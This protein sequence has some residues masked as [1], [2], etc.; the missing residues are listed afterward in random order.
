MKHLLQ[1]VVCLIASL[2]LTTSL[3]AQDESKSYLTLP[4]AGLQEGVGYT[5]QTNGRSFWYSNANRLVTSH[6]AG[7]TNEQFDPTD[8]AAVF[9]F[10]SFDDNNYI[11]SVKQ[12][13]FLS[14]DVSLTAKG[15]IVYIFNSGSTDDYHTF[16][17]FTQDKRDLNINDNGNSFVFNGWSVPDAGDQFKVTATSIT[18]NAD[19]VRTQLIQALTADQ[20]AV[21]LA[22]IHDAQ[23]LG[24]DVS[25]A[26]A[27]YDNPNATPSAVSAAI[28]A[29]A[30]AM[31][32]MAT[33]EHPVDVTEKIVN[34]Y[35]E[36]NF[37]G[38]ETTVKNLDENR[39]D[40]RMSMYPPAMT[41]KSW[42]NGNDS[43]SF[44][45]RQHQVITGLQN[46]VYKFSLGAYVSTLDLYNSTDSLEYVFANDAKTLIDSPRPKIYHVFVRVTDGTL[47]V[48]LS[49]DSILS[50]RTYIDNANLIYYGNSLASYRHL[51]TALQEDVDSLYGEG[52]DA[53]YASGYMTQ[54]H[55]IAARIQVAETPEAALALF[56][57]EGLKAK[58]ELVKS[59]SYYNQV[60][61]EIDDLEEYIWQMGFEM[62]D[63]QSRLKEIYAAHTME[64]QELGEL[65]GTLHDDIVNFI[66]DN[67]HGADDQYPNGQE[68]PFL[69]NSSFEGG[70]AEG[71]NLTGAEAG[72]GASGVLEFWSKKGWDMY[73][74]F[75]GMKPGIWRFSVEGFYRTAGGSGGSQQKWNDNKGQNKGSNVVRSFFGINSRVA[76]LA[77][78][79]SEGLDMTQYGFTADTN[80]NTTSINYQNRTSDNYWGMGHVWKG[81]DGDGN[82]VYEDRWF[83][84][85]IY[86]CD[87]YFNA[88]DD[89]VRSA[90]GFVGPDGKLRLRI[91]NND[92]ENIDGDDWTIIGDTHLYY[93]GAD[94]DSIRPYLQELID[95]A[96]PLSQ[97]SL[98]KGVKADLTAKLAAAETSA[99]GSDGVDMISK[100]TDLQ[101]SMEDARVSVEKYAELKDKIDA[102]LDAQDLYGDAATQQAQTEAQT[103][104]TTASET[105]Q[106]GN[107]RVDEVDGIIAQI[108]E[109]IFNLK[110]PAAEA[111]D[112]AP[113]DWTFYLN[114]PKYQDGT[115]G[116]TFSAGNVEQHADQGMGIAEGYS[117]QFNTYQDVYGLRKGTYK[118]TVQGFYRQGNDDK[119]AK[120]YQLYLANNLGK[121]DQ[122][123]E[124][125]RK[126]EPFINRGRFYANADTVV[127]HS[128]VFIPE[129]D[130]DKAAF[131]SAPGSG[132]K[133]YVDSLTT[134]SVVKYYFPASRATAALRFY[135]GYY[136][137]EIYTQ[138]GN[139]GHL[140][141]GA[142][143]SD[144]LSNDW[145]VFTNWTL[146]SYGP[147][148]K[149]ASLTGITNA[150]VSSVVASE[151]IFTIDGRQVSRLQKGINIIR[152][153]MADGHTSVKKILVK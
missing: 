72:G 43:R 133:T 84:D 103:L 129:S 143:N 46:G 59:I 1:T 11:Y 79:A 113:Q 89:Y 136:V 19:A 50:N 60:E 57:G 40:D 2:S 23:E 108:D 104:Y 83:P 140:R 82:D 100:Y 146:T 7:L 61:K 91:F 36:E 153:T 128:V 87:D 18:Y 41:G 39:V 67:I 76:P 94:A 90:M 152:T 122:L 78:F 144:F 21:L 109:A 15:D 88:N 45:G 27:V 55:D 62:E 132:W 16:F 35:F 3:W 8:S 138:V 115:R 137:N 114:N 12:K 131:Q 68:Y 70:S 99:A 127:A 86:G 149:H 49:Q 125:D 4:E 42:C 96:T 75:E 117:T 107:C 92:T 148:S 95:A 121:T 71:W 10:V 77:N 26:Q 142:C 93:I 9:G 31:A 52:T 22:R 116:W 145:V 66:K 124:A 14:K 74:D 151:K 139:D 141:I 110:I 48:G 34:P 147:N 24:V 51:G 73:Q 53:I 47:D 112:D 28:Q 56:Y 118:V 150:N 37:N 5:L 20:K 130:D 29:L 80:P 119:N 58:A 25:D 63:F 106:N 33:P 69:V 65:L 54:V 13:K 134:E 135:D 123:S 64:N 98:P 38:W 97:Q 6:D 105:W 85:R 32:A 101:T 30:D 102:L 17:S 111:T 44:M 126:A 120:S 81:V